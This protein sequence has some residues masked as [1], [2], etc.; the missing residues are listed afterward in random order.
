MRG[1]DQRPMA[2]AKVAGGRLPARPKRG[3]KPSLSA[4][5]PLSPLPLGDN[6]CTERA[7]VF[8]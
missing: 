8:H 2:T 3:Q 4:A 1:A 6:D 7:N 5:T